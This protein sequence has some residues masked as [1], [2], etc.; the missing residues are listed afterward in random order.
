M[1]DIYELLL[2]NLLISH[3][4]EAIFIEGMHLNRVLT[5][6]TTVQIFFF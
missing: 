2:F 5:S 4:I 3:H 6:I 1:L